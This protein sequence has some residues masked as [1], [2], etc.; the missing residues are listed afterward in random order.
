[1]S[2][3][4]TILIGNVGN[5]PELKSFSDGTAV[6]N[7]SLAT[8]EKW[9]DKNSGEQRE[10]VEWHRVVIV[11]KLAEIAAQYLAKGSKVYIEGQNRTREWEKD[12]VKRYT[13]EVHV[14]MRGTMQMLDSRS[15]NTEA[16][17]QRTQQPARRPAPQSSA[18]GGQQEPDYDSFDDDK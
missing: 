1:M 18:Q 2:V 8:N 5:D 16:P 6:C 10:R 15:D 7:L 4:K 14:G 3:S 9:R 17:A 11:G 12:G 13:T